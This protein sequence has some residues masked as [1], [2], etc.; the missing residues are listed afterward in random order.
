MKV[1]RYAARRDLEDL[2]KVA[3]WAYLV[4]RFD[5]PDAG[6]PDGPVTVTAPP[7]REER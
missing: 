5:R 7:T 4:W 1:R 3:A 6:S 2:L